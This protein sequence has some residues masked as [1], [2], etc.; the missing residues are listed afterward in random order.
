MRQIQSYM[1]FEALLNLSVVSRSCERMTRKDRLAAIRMELPDYDMAQDD[2]VLSGSRYPFNYIVKH[3]MELSTTPAFNRFNGTISLTIDLEMREYLFV[4]AGARGRLIK[5]QVYAKIFQVLR[6]LAP[7]LENLR[8]ING[9]DSRHNCDFYE[10][11]IDSGLIFPKVT[12][13]EVQH[14][15][16]EIYHLLRYFLQLVPRVQSV[17]VKDTGPKT[18]RDRMSTDYAYT[19]PVQSI[20]SFNHLTLITFDLGRGP[21]GNTVLPPDDYNIDPHEA[22]SRGEQIVHEIMDT[23]ALAPRLYTLDFIWDPRYEEENAGLDVARWVLQESALEIMRWAGGIRSQGSA[24]SISYIG[25]S[26]RVT[27]IDASEW[28]WHSDALLPD[29]VSEHLM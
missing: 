26:L 8:I 4:G 29:F 10:Q 1:S 9:L 16:Y 3:I 6:A 7:Q 12:I 28:S 14:H 19:D 18:T 22:W 23:V 2:K 20:G 15:R 13:L 21:I 24:S 27:M 25:A 17:K 11:C 5:R